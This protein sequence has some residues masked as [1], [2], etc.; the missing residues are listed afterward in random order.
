MAGDGI[1]VLQLQGIEIRVLA[2]RLVAPLL[3]LYVR[4]VL[5]HSDVQGVLLLVCEGG[6]FR[7]EGVQADLRRDLG[8]VVIRENEPRIGEVEPVP[9]LEVLY[10]QQFGHIAVGYVVYPRDIPDELVAVLDYHK[11]LSP[12]HPLLI[13][14]D[15]RP[16][17]GIVAV[18]PLVRTAQDYRVVLG[19]IREVGRVQGLYQ[20]AA[21]DPHH[22]VET[23]G[24]QSYLV[25]SIYRIPEGVFGNEGPEPGGVPE[26]P[27]L[28]LL[29]NHFCKGTVP[30][31]AEAVHI[32]S[33]KC[34]GGI[35]ADRRQLG[36]VPYQYEPAVVA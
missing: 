5:V 3:G 13:V 6:G 25:R 20:F 26:D 29:A 32:L 23:F 34:R 12:D 30:H 18:G 21:R 19:I 14:E 22:I 2:D 31:P 33:G 36:R 35:Q 24:P 7:L 15:L 1:G 9:V 4:I 8:I 28:L 16:D 17:A 10:R 11:F 27:G